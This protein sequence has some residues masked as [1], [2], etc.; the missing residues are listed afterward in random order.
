MNWGEMSSILRVTGVFLEVLLIFNVIIVAHELGHFLAAKWRGLKVEKFG[1]WFGPPILKGTCGGVEFSLGCIPAGGF[2]AI[3]QMANPEVIEGKSSAL[4]TEA[5]PSDKIIVALAGPVASVLCA[6]LFACVVWVTGKPAYEA[7]TTTV[8]GYVSKGSGADKAGLEAGDRILSVDGREVLKF[9]GLSNMKNSVVW[10]IARSEGGRV[11]LLVERNGDVLEKEIETAI[12]E[13]KAVGRRKLPQIGISPAT[14]CLIFR[15]KP[16]M[17]AERGGVGKGDVI[18][19][20]NGERVFSPIRVNEIIDEGIPLDIEIE[21]DGSTEEVRVYPEKGAGGD[22]FLIGI[23]WD[24]ESIKT[25][26]HPNP[27]DQIKGAV[28]VMVETLFAVISPNTEIGAQ[29]LSG[30]VGIMRLYYLLFE[31]PEGWRL[32]LWFSVVFNINL[33]ILN[34]LPIP[35]L[36]G[37]H[38]LLASLEWVRKKKMS[39]RVVNALQTACALLILSFMLYVTGYDILDYIGEKFLSP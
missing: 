5:K 24:F 1:I 12:P 16:D 36:D 21:R 18:R 4:I 9:S 25:I 39:D 26:E 34:L 13:N 35:V 31:M 10:N 37:G 27:L 14:T 38:I 23:E 19:K 29:H 17:P 6:F 7:E 32:A 22:G 2:V 33:A 3:P 11:R 30:P 28:T 15:T 20:I 8:V